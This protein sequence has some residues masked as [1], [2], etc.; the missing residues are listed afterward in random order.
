[1]RL[2]RLLPRFRKAYRELALL[3]SRERWSRAD[4]EAFQLGRLND[5]WRQAVKSVPYYRQLASDGDL[6]PTFASLAEFRASVPVLDK[7]PVREARRSFLSETPAPGR[8]HF[9]GGSTG[10]TTRVYWPHEA[11]QEMLRAKYRFHAM[12]GLDIFD[13][14]AFLWGHSAS[15]APGLGGY[16]GRIR[17]PI[18]DTLRNRLRLSAY[19]MGVDDLRQHV[20]RIERYRPAFI[21]A[22]STSA[23]LLAIE[24]EALGFASD[25]LKLVVLTAEP[26][27]PHFIERV[28]QA[29]HVPSAIE[30]GSSECGLI[31]TQGPDGRLRV[32]EDT[33]L[34][35]TLPRADGRF[36]IVVSVLINSSFPLLRYAIG[37]ATDGPLE[38]T[39]RGFATMTNVV[40][41]DN[42]VLLSRSG[43]YLHSLWFDDLFENM[44]GLRRWQVHQL[45]DG[46]LRVSV[47]LQADV[48]ID[49]TG[50]ARRLQEYVEGFPVDVR[51][52]S[53]VPQ[54]AAGK[55]R[56]VL[57]EAVPRTSPGGALAGDRK[58]DVREPDRMSRIAGSIA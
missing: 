9:T 19:R 8:W 43:R 40:G 12:W 52:V 28:E 16:V 10:V 50:L 22:Y 6:P 27:F 57:S 49:T 25:T 38:H 46:A 31:A 44:E 26:A 54:T 55:H 58:R 37:D 21:Y 14:C 4:I 32:R 34:V 53:E 23:Y 5:V 20:R 29:F 13:R 45:A 42:D 33:T 17:V 15:F 41:R 39:D 1:M 18:E 2:L 30:Y 47:E 3:E 36:D 56:W 11:H 7:R 35:E 48:S 24:A 51:I